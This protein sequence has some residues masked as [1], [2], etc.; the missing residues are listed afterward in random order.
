VTD[1]LGRVQRVGKVN[2]LNR[3]VGGQDEFL[4]APDCHQRGIVPNAEF[5]PFSKPEGSHPFMLARWGRQ[6]LEPTY[7]FVFSSKQVFTPK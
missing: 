7:E 1:G 3:H 6:C 2:T 5:H 4:A